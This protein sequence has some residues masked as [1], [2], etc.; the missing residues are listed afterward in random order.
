MGPFF[1][2]R[3]YCGQFSQDASGLHLFALVCE[4]LGQLDLAAE[5]LVQAITVLERAYEKSEDSEIEGRYAIA[6]VTLGRVNLAIGEYAKA[7]EAFETVL[8]LLEASAEKGDG[9]E[10]GAEEKP[11]PPEKS[12]LHI[13]AQ[14]GCGLA[15]FK[16]GALEEALTAFEGAA[17]RASSGNFK[18]AQ[19]HVTI[20]TAQTLWAIGS[21]EARDA[22]RDQLLER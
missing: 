15:N 2:L 22:A 10:E 14:F 18:T 7:K 5:L 13:Q 6:N 21:D 11:A 9:E 19:G 17:E 4:R 16:L 12:L 3:R 20:L 1:A 8:G